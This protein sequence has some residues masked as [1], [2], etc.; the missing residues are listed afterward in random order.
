MSRFNKALCFLAMN[1]NGE[2]YKG[3]VIQRANI[4]H[5]INGEIKKSAWYLMKFKKLSLCFAPQDI[6][7]WAFNHDV[8]DEPDVEFV[9][10]YGENVYLYEL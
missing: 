8:T 10:T 6:K 5:V 7:D 4:H 2:I 9:N 1:C 3:D